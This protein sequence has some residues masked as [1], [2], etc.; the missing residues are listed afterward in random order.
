MAPVKTIVCFG[1]SNTWGYDPA[2][3]DRFPPDV[4]WTGVLQRTLGDGYKVIEEGLNGRTTNVD[5]PLQPHRNGLTYLPPCLESHKPL[6]L[7]TIMLGTNDLK[8]RFGRSGSDIAEAAAQLAGVAKTLPVGPGGAFPQ[9]LLMVPPPVAQITDY[10]EML[11]GAEEKSRRFAQHFRT[12]AAWFAV[13]VLDAGDVIR[14]SDLDGIH[15]ERDEHR[16]LG[17]AVAREVQRLLA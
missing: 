4:R 11:L 16:K 17:E 2:T 13:P 6:E 3:Q 12:Y 14:S 1:D 15:F 7:V 9:V 8:C 10:A 5:D